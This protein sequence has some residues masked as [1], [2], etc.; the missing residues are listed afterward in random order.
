[1]LRMCL[2]I[3]INSENEET[4]SFLVGFLQSSRFPWK[5]RFGCDADRMNQ[6]YEC[7]MAFTGACTPQNCTHRAW[8]RAG[9]KSVLKSSRFP[10]KIR[11]GSKPNLPGLGSAAVFL[12]KLTP[13]VRFQTAPIGLGLDSL[14]RRLQCR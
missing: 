5:I 7:L 13:M 2:F 12:L 9:L 6:R 4:F 8:V 3:P 1:M 10:W 14:I 11:F